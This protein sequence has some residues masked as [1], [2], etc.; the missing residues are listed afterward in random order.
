MKRRIWLVLLGF[1]TAGAA[2][3]EIY[4]WVDEDGHV[5]F[6]DKPPPDSNATAVEMRKPPT[7]EAVER[8]RRHFDERLEQARERV[9]EPARPARSAT[10]PP[11]EAARD[12]RAVPCFAPL[13]DFVQSPAGDGFEPIT[14]TALDAGQRAMLVNL[15]RRAAGHWRGRI[16]D[17]ACEGD[18]PAGERRTVS[19]DIHDAAATW[20]STD[21]LLVVDSDIGGEEQESS[22]V[23]VQF[24]VGDRLY[25]STVEPAGRIAVSGNQVELLSLEDDRV[26]FVLKNRSP[27]AGT[28]RPLRT[29]VR[30]WEMS[31]GGVTFTELYF[32]NERLSGSRAWR[33]T[34]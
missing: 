2:L 21:S 11:R 34:K 7:P 9:L 33:L 31:G 3:G 20:E 10:V 18:P 4:R 22:R 8:A 17:L 16:E 28:S 24:E 19:L 23:F 13:S 6:G 29:E 5:Q 14:P 32:R 30:Y 15:L 1:L 12:P 26:A 25:F 27:G